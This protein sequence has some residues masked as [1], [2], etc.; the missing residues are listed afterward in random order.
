MLKLTLLKHKLHKFLNDTLS[1]RGALQR[2]RYALSSH[3]LVAHN[4]HLGI[5]SNFLKFVG[6]CLGLV[7]LMGCAPAAPTELPLAPRRTAT[8][9][10]LP[11]QPVVTLAPGPTTTPASCPAVRDVSYPIR[12]D[13]LGDY[14]ATLAAYLAQGGDPANLVTLLT[15][16]GA[17]PAFGNPIAQADVTHDGTVD[18]IVSFV[19]PASEHYP[20]EAGWAIF[21]C[22]DGTILRRYT[23]LAGEWFG[24]NLIGAQDVTQDGNAD[25]V[26][27]EISCG[28]HT[29]WDVLHVWSWNGTDFEERVGG[30]FTTPY[31]AFYLSHGEIAVSSHDIASVGAGPQRPMTTTLAWNGSVITVTGHAVGPAQFRYHVF[32]D[33]DAALFAGDAVRAARLYQR[34]LADDDLL[35]WEVYFSTEEERRWFDALAHW[36]LL[37]LDVY[38]GRPE[39]AQTHYERLRD[40]Y[41]AGDAGSPVSAIAQHFWASYQSSQSL[42]Y[43]C[44][45]ALAVPE[46][47]T[48]LDF[49]NG[50]GYANPVYELPDLCG[51]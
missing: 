31:A 40:D 27:S 23:Y 44:Q 25:L 22:Q 47:Q 13:L 50:F 11:T 19:D 7:L 3:S 29:C 18:I 28:M 38:A 37:L 46:A 51:F 33:G 14:A 43:G 2:R 34:V 24:L 48:V 36:R 4:D 30:E 32:R 6:V 12:P 41:P 26:F 5:C 1:E 10:M 39:T 20:P 45:A 21:S 35:H 17:T 42:P 9:V 8:P 49:L 16:W 15:R